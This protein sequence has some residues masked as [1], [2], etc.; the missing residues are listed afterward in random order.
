MR[1]ALPLRRDDGEPNPATV[2]WRGGRRGPRAAGRLDD[3]PTGV[4]TLASASACLAWDCAR[5]RAALEGRPSVHLITNTRA[6]P[7]AR[8]RRSS[9]RP[10]RHWTA[11]RTPRSCSE[12]TA[13]SRS[14]ARGVPRR[15]R[16][17]RALR[18]A[19]APARACASLR[20]ASHGR[21]DP[22]LRTGRRAR[23]CTRR[24]TR[25]TACSPT[26]APGCSMGGRAL[27]RAVSRRR[28][29]GAAPRR[30]SLPGLPP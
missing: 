16:R 23:R 18:L 8:V 20:R 6:L 24:S 25:A 11:S 5:V 2:G 12:A 14:P 19:R 17:R 10:A 28:R 13:R 15:P 3:D 1:I 7:A 27:G 26:P 9:P 30:A 22:P 29:A 21:W 4:Q